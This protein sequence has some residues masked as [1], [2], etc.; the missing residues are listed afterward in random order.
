[1]NTKIYILSFLTALVFAYG[2]N[3]F[4]DEKP[5]KNTS[6]VITSIDQLEYIL[7]SYSIFYEESNRAALYSSDDYGLLPELYDARANSYAVAGVQFATWD[8]ENLPFD[9]RESFWP[10]EYRKI[11]HANMIQ[12]YLPKVSGSEEDKARIK[13]ESHLIRAVSMWNLVQT[14]SLPYTEANANEPGIVIKQSTSFEESYKRSTI[15]ETYDFIEKDI[16][17]ALKLT[18]ELDVVNNKYR[19]WRGSKAA[20][21]AFAARYWLHRNDYEKA[22]E[23]A[24][25]ALSEHD[26][27]MNYNTDM[28][29]SSIPSNVTVEGEPVPVLFPYTHDNQLDLTDMMEWKELYYFRLMYNESWWYI[30]SSELLSLYDKDHD[31]RY[32]YHI[33]ENYSYDRG[34]TNPPYE[35]PGYIFFFKDRIPSGPTVAEMLL[36]KA[37]AHARLDQLAPALEAVNKLRVNRIDSNAPN[38]AINISASTSEDAL[39]LILEERRREM[40]FSQRWFDIR[41]FNNNDEPSDDVGPLTRNFYGYSSSSVTPSTGIVTYTLES[42]S[43]RYAAPIPNTEIESSEGELEQNIYN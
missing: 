21:N 27:M 19:S 8:T 1:M 42:N 13:S 5:S 20:A 3:D 29:Y 14:Y 40:P 32:R 12:S 6:L 15:E 37:E 23:Y 39:T 41:R 26:A 28:R 35:Y 2:C 10:N 17:E 33:V 43:R 24:N 22:L 30:P 18:N 16:E 38:S 25:V 31:L 9:A 34:V 11:F 4:L 36:T 7:N